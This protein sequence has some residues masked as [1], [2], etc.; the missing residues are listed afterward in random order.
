MTKNNCNDELVCLKNNMKKK[1]VKSIRDM[2]YK[3]N[4]SDSE[5][6]L[7]TKETSDPDSDPEEIIIIS[8]NEHKVEQIYLYENYDY[9]KDYNDELNDAFDD[10]NRSRQLEV[11]Q[12][13]LDI[14]TDSLIN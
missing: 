12:L 9:E 5:A 13:K 11:V 10:T 1:F 3:L 14:L 6:E 8:N 2:V 4:E 7:F